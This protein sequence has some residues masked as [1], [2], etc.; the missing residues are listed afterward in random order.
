MPKKLAPMAIA[1]DFDGTLAPGNMQEYDFVPKIGMK[2]ADFW[3]EVTDRARE[4]QGDNILVYMGLMLEKA[5]ASRISVHRSDFENFGKSVELYDGVLGWFDRINLYAKKNN[6]RIDHFIVSSGIREM[7][8]GTPIAKNFKSIFASGFWYDHNG[9]AHWPALALNYTTKTQFLFRINKGVLDIW[10]HSSVNRYIEPAKRPLPFSNMV[11]IGDG[12]TDIPCFRLVKE[13]GGHSVAVYKPNARGAKE[14]AEKLIADGR[15][16]MAAPANYSDSA[17]LDQ[18]V[19]AI[20][21]KIAA[22]AE[23]RRLGKRG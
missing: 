2:P 19:K 11:F 10:D 8:E 23:L 18:Q 22:D 5:R 12:D 7:I 3:S 1:Y 17:P 9:V 15:V 6:V 14:K 4:I 16:H 13:K 21:M 20:I